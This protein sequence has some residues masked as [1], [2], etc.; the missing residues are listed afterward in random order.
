MTPHN[1]SNSDE[2]VPVELLSQQVQQPNERPRSSSLGNRDDAPNTH[3]SKVAVA[4]TSYNL[5]RCKSDTT[6]SKSSQNH[7]VQQLQ[8]IT[9]GIALDE[10]KSPEQYLPPLSP[11][12]GNHSPHCMYYNSPLIRRKSLPNDSN[13]TASPQQQ[14]SKGSPQLSQHYQL[15]MKQQLPPSISNTHSYEQDQ[16]NTA[17][18]HRSQNSYSSVDTSLK[19]ATF[20]QQLRANSHRDNDSDSIGDSLV[21]SIVFHY[22]LGEEVPPSEYALSASSLK[23]SGMDCECFNDAAAQNYLSET[24]NLGSLENENYQINTIQTIESSFQ[25]INRYELIPPQ[26]QDQQPSETEQQR[27]LPYNERKRLTEIREKKEKK[28]ARKEPKLIATKTRETNEKSTLI[29]KEAPIKEEYGQNQPHGFRLV[30]H[31]TAL[32]MGKQTD[33][34]MQRKQY[35]SVEYA[36]KQ[37]RDRGEAFLR[38]TQKQRSKNREQ[39]QSDELH[40]VTVPVSTLH[41]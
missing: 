22:T 11:F 23:V 3:S 16:P 6:S 39:N 15:P 13:V 19:K 37:Y 8:T 1:K 20:I 7:S 12:K 29:N 26:S 17:A 41:A 24:N 25:P 40:H 21:D 4:T 38:K 14:Q 28:N 33:S 32:I 10:M 27:I 9:S 36:S 5:V 35:G 34:N 18:T 31:L 2:K 30:D